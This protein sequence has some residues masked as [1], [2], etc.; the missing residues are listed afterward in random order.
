[1]RMKYIISKDDT[2]VVFSDFQSHQEVASAL[3]F[4]V[5][6]AGFCHINDDKEFVC[7]G[8]SVSLNVKSRG[9]VDSLIIN[10][11]FGLVDSDRK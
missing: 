3:S 1:M 5:L 9:T 8:D 7:Y 10:K 2:P 4:L 6:G 11:V